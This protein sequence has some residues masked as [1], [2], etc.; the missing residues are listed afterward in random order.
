M[1]KEVPGKTRYEDQDTKTN[2]ARIKT[3]DGDIED[4]FLVKAHAARYAVD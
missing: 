3:S 2:S 1:G 4:C